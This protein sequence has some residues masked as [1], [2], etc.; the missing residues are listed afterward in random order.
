M[1]WNLFSHFKILFLFCMLFPMRE[2]YAFN[3]KV[4]SINIRMD[5]SRD[6][7]N[8]WRIRKIQLFEYVKS[9]KMDVLCLQECCK[10]QLDDFKKAFPG[11]SVVSISSKKRQ[12]LNVPI[13]YSTRKFDCLESGTFWL[14]EHP[15]IK[16]KGWDAASSRLA[17][18]AKL[19]EKRTGI[20]F[21]VYNTHLDNVGKVAKIEGMKL[22]KHHI[23]IKANN[24]PS[25]LTGDMNSTPNSE[26]YKLALVEQ[27]PMTD[28]Y[29]AAPRKYG[30]SYSFHKYGIRNSRRI[31]HVFLSESIMVRDV[32][33]PQEK[34]ENGCY[35][36]DHNPV[37]VNI[38]IK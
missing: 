9:Q 34:K 12:C 29:E 24:S 18:W 27:I 36:S 38:V 8:P 32:C 35:M 30:V 3:L 21:F 11:Y 7:L 14:S 37:V 20:I 2:G 26:A 1:N 33:I 13:L 19:K 25:I 31:D 22:I 6:S 10:N 28:A 23:K 15:E 5:T 4:A 17:T 16:G